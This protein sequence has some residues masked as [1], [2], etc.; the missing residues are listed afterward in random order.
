MSCIGF[1]ARVVTTKNHYILHVRAR[2][3][4]KALQ[5]GRDGVEYDSRKIDCRASTFKKDEGKEVTMKKLKSIWITFHRILQTHSRVHK[6]ESKVLHKVK[7][8]LMSFQCKLSIDFVVSFKTFLFGSLEPK[9]VNYLS[10]T[11]FLERY[12]VFLN[13]Q[14]QDSQVNLNATLRSTIFK[15]AETVHF[16]LSCY[17]GNAIRWAVSASLKMVARNRPS[18]DL[19][20]CFI[21]TLFN[22]LCKH[23]Q[24]E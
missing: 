23:V 11:K 6:N 20:Y 7:E 5:S 22:I 1:Y 9:M 24:R 4:Q 2:P 17:L 18:A 8:L 19:F 10:C 3:I 21:F 12:T 14:T 16:I 13:Q 15:S